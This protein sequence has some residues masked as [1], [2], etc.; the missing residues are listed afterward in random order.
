LTF[1]PE[2]IETNNPDGDT[3]TTLQTLTAAQQAL[4]D[5]H[6]TQTFPFVDF[7]GKK[8]LTSAQYDPTLLEG[9]SFD[10]IAGDIGTN[11]TTIG[12]AIDASA[13]LLVQTICGT[14]TNHQPADVCNS[15]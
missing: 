15:A 8:D 1:V 4:W 11:S 10:T 14:L 2:E 5:S 7:G 13:V 9:S 6:T 12:A 3:Y